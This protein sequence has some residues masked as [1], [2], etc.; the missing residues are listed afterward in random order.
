MAG[1]TPYTFTATG[2][3]TTF[4]W[5]F[6]DGRT[7]TGQS[8]THTYP[9]GGRFTVTLTGRSGGKSATVSASVEVARGMAGAWAGPFN[10]RNS[11]IN[12]NPATGS[13]AAHDLGLSGTYS[14]QFDAGT[15][16][17]TL[18]GEGICPCELRFVISIPGV[19]TFEFVGTRMDENTIVG[20][21]RGEAFETP[22]MLVRQ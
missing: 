7:A 1:L 2:A 5:D 22:T 17:G 16:S 18:F 6:G 3:A 15:I 19:P 4:E 8:V 14:D 11:V 13:I 9:S 10:N 12:F 21:F 20:S